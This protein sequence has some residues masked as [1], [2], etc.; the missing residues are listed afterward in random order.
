MITLAEALAVVREARGNCFD[1]YEEFVDLYLFF[2][3]EE[4]LTDGGLNAPV[5]IEKSTGI[6]WGLSTFAI[7]FPKLLDDNNFLD[8]G[9]VA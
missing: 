1:S 7:K 3:N 5:V 8:A 4:L 9:M 6:L 2:D